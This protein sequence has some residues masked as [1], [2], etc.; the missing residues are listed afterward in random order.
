MEQPFN[1]YAPRS[2]RSMVAGGE[3]RKIRGVNHMNR[4]SIYTRPNKPLTIPVRKRG[5]PEPLKTS[6]LPEVV[7]VDKATECHVTPDDVA[8][9]M[10]EYLG[11]VGDFMTLEPEAGTGQLVR[12]LLA[13]GHS[14]CEI[15]AVERHIGLF[16]TLYK[17]EGI[18][19]AGLVNACFLEWAD[20]VQ[21]R[22]LFPRIIMN[23]PFREV[24]KHISA[25]LS[26][27]GRGGH[28]EPATLVALVPVTFQHEEAEHLEDLPDDTFVTARV[29]TKLIRFQK[30]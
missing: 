5:E 4:P 20:E 16:Q 22:T 28:A 8:R 11:P 24:R 2:N 7:A 26:L 23:P 13:A 15:C 29:R 1:G 25:A 12:A 6:E 17:V 30:G 18:S 21:G 19:G 3:Q 14:P 10:V 27:L 9:R